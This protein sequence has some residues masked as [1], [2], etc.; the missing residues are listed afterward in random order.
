MTSK[1]DVPLV[2]GIEQRLGPELKKLRE[3]SGISLRTLA[4]RAGFSP[5]FISQ[6]ENGQAS[7]SIA[8][9]EKIAA[10]LNV[11]LA[12]LFASTDTTEVVVVRAHARPGFRSAW[13]R[14]RVDSLIPA[15][16]RQS[17]EAL[18]VT[19]EPGGTSGKHAAGVSNDQLAV[20][21]SG[22]LTLTLVEDTFELDKGDAVLIRAATP[23]RWQNLGHVAAQVLLVSALSAR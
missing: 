8:S 2:E 10:T 7:P 1:R 23:H 11:R 13:S 14:A 15:G 12:D 16:K 5:S 18:M 19:I 3:A 21:F 22:Q 9:L 6:V 17:V 20:V 4:D